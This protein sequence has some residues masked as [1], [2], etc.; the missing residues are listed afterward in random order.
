MAFTDVQLSSIEK[1]I[2]LDQ[3]LPMEKH[4]YFHTE[5]EVPSSLFEDVVS[6]HPATNALIPP[7]P[8]ESFYQAGIANTVVITGYDTVF[9]NNY[10]GSVYHDPID[11]NKT[12]AIANTLLH[13]VLHELNVNATINVESEML[14]S[15][16]DCLSINGNCTVMET[17][18]SYETDSITSQ[19]NHKPMNKFAGTYHVQKSTYSYCR[20]AS[21]RY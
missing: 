9:S 16:L 5:S 8:G 4:L 13:F 1:V 11:V 15:L 12:E 7:G 18:M 2:L 20:E 3:L 6:I 14:L 10:L 19:L 21:T 17:I